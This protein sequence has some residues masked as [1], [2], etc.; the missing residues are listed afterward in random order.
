LATACAA[1]L[2]PAPGRFSTTTGWPTRS[3]SHVAMIRETASAPPPGGNPTIQ[4][5][6]RAG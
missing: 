5:S 1:R 6:G 4:R 2:L 3:D